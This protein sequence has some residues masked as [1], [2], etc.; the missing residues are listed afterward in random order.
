MTEDQHAISGYVFFIDG[1]AVSWNPKQQKIVSLLMMESKYIAVTHATQGVMWLCSLIAQVFGPFNHVTT[2]F[3]DNQSVI[4]LT[5]DH[6]YHARINVHFHFIC[7]II[8]NG[9]IQL[10]YHPTNNMVADT[11]TKA[12]LSPKV[13]HFASELG[14][15]NVRGSVGI[16]TITCPQCVHS[17]MHHQPLMC[18]HHLKCTVFGPSQ[19]STSHSL[20][21]AQFTRFTFGLPVINISSLIILTH[22]PCHLFC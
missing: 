1:G 18:S 10:I 7:W 4:A 9:N 2:L 20:F 13:K 6:Q 16:A 8:E 3:S 19:F 15:C 14:L 22:H 5:T 11:L 21:T 12:L 17:D